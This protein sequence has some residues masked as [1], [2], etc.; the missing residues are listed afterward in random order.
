MNTNE[1]PRRQAGPRPDPV[2]AQNDAQIAGARIEP[3][4]RASPKRH[5]DAAGEDHRVERLE[6]QSRSRVGNPTAKRSWRTVMVYG[7]AIFFAFL[8]AMVIGYEMSPTTAESQ[9]AKQQWELWAK[10]AKA[11]KARANGLAQKLRDSQGE[12]KQALQ[13]APP[14]KEAEKAPAPKAVAK[15]TADPKKAAQS[16]KA[17]GNP[18]AALV[19][20]K[21]AATPGKFG[22]QVCPENPIVKARIARGLPPTV[23]A[24]DVE[25]KPGVKGVPIKNGCAEIMWSKYKDPD[26]GLIRVVQGLPK[27]TVNGVDY[28]YTIGKVIPMDWLSCGS[29]R[30]WVDGTKQCADGH[31][32]CVD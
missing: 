27:K 3:R 17:K 19:K 24:C 20:S 23:E 13:K 29:L 6:N 15:K 28:D 21:L 5:N 11:E 26:T 31:T 8:L 25:G 4:N 9:H 22:D 16:S 10:D 7:L 2:D 18:P 12:L 32:N 1:K 30:V 14:A